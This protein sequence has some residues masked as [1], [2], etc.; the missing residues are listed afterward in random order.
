MF[1]I[2]KNA[3]KDGWERLENREN[4]YFYPKRLDIKCPHPSC[5]SDFVNLLITWKN[6]SLF[7][8][9]IMKCG[10]CK[11]PS[12]IFLINPQKEENLIESSHIFLYP[13]PQ[14]QK[15]FDIQQNTIDR[16]RKISPTFLNLFDQLEKAEHSQLDL[17]TGMGYRKALEFLIKDY[18]IFKNHDQEEEI[19]KT[20]LGNCINNYIDEP[21]IKECAKRAAWLGNDETHYT[22]QWEDKDI[23]DLKTLMEL[24]L[25]WLTMEFLSQ[26]YQDSMPKP[27]KGRK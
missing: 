25:Y 26:E 13:I 20:A 14:P 6:N 17:L 1:E 11:Q 15:P 12:H 4:G 21:H 16:L 3:V 7:L 10:R 19:K 5:G 22:R 27:E 24:T 18:L 23:K 9:A 2:D 8:W